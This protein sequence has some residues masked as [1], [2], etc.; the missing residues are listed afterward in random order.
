LD[1]EQFISNIALL[2]EDP[3]QRILFLTLK[4]I[5]VLG[6]FNKSIL[7]FYKYQTLENCIVLIE[8]MR[9]GVL[10]LKEKDQT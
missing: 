9:S 10:S 6:R 3:D 7:R 1:N 2:L 4:I 8:G 5:E